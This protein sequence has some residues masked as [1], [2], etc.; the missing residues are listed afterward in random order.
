MYQFTV[1]GQAGYIF[2]FSGCNIVNIHHC[3]ITAVYG[4]AIFQ[5]VQCDVD[6]IGNNIH[7]DC[8][9][10]CGVQ[11]WGDA[12]W[13][14]RGLNIEGNRF[15]NIA[16]MPD[17]FVLVDAKGVET[18]QDFTTT[19]Y[20]WQFG[21]PISL[22]G[23][24][25][26]VINNLFENSSGLS[27]GADH[28]N[29]SSLPESR[30]LISENSFI[31]NSDRLK[32][33]NPPGFIWVENHQSALVTNNRFSFR[34][35]A[36]GDG[37]FQLCRFAI[38]QYNT[39]KPYFEYSGNTYIAADTANDTTATISIITNSNDAVI[40]IKDNMHHAP[41]SDF[42]YL[43]TN[44]ASRPCEYLHVTG[45]NV[46]CREFVMGYNG[47]V[48]TGTNFFKLPK[49]IVIANN[50]AI[51]CSGDLFNQRG[52]YG[53]TDSSLLIS[54]N[55]VVQAGKINMINGT[56]DVHVARNYAPTLE[57]M[58]NWSP[59]ATQNSK[60]SIINNSAIGKISLLTNT[61]V[62]ANI[63]GNIVYGETVLNN[64][65][66]ESDVRGNTFMASV[67]LKGTH[68]YLHITQNLF[69][70]RLLLINALLSKCDITHN[71]FEGNGFGIYGFDPSSTSLQLEHCNMISNSFISDLTFNSI[72][73]PAFTVFMGLNNIINNSIT[74]RNDQ[75]PMRICNKIGSANLV[76]SPVSGASAERPV[77]QPA[78]LEFLDLTI[79]KK[80]IWWGANW[81][82]M[83]GNAV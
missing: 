41:L 15:Y 74:N 19:K 42:I 82:D 59:T 48:F 81:K 73:F 56:L 83:T 58:W 30:I 31:A 71:I 79:Q 45:N 21:Q 66:V 27:I 52:E 51:I 33:F 34:K 36:T 54:D 44:S 77:A 46:T 76:V 2:T 68:N 16:L 63:T 72:E 5:L 60:I 14:N 13:T 20:A 67:S 40:N 39:E 7:D 10:D 1:S 61:N 69:K 23:N 6:F 12:Q 55:N 29:T 62:A 57:F 75:A 25:M 47:E 3:D 8:F 78:G 18:P 28:Y 64:L 32:G 24:K 17:Q 35:R 4:V 37:A 70:N 53:N 50:P 38:A 11:I 65:L 26:N 49:Q 43:N 80:I 22:L 9:V